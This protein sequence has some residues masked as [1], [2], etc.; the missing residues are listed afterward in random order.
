MYSIIHCRRWFE[1]PVR[2]LVTLVAV[3]L[4]LA[5]GGDGKQGRVVDQSLYRNYVTIEW[6]VGET[7]NYRR[8]QEGSVDIK[9]V[10]AAEG[11]KY[12]RDHLPKVGNYQRIVVILYHSHWSVTR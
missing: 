5:E 2:F 8:G 11:E 12:Y 4:L 6:D 1:R 3:L 10:T 9:C 7:H